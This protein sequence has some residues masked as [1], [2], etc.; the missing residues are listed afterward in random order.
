[1]RRR[2]DFSECAWILGAGELDADGASDTSRPRANAASV[3][4][5]WLHQPW[6]HLDSKV[7]FE[8]TAGWLL[9]LPP[10]AVVD[11]RYAMGVLIRSREE[12]HQPPE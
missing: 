2:R 8:D 3:S 7:I 1:M 4:P 11:P 12:F 5:T 9:G 10:S 6:A